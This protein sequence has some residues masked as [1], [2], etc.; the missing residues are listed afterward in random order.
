M[1]DYQ[2]I[3]RSVHSRTGLRPAGHHGQARGERFAPVVIDEL[4][5]VLPRMPL[6]FV[7]A[8]EG[9]SG[10]RLVGVQGLDDERNLYLH[11]R[12]EQ[13]VGGYIPACYR[14]HPFALVPDAHGELVL[15]VDQESGLLVEDPVEDAIDFFD[16]EG[17]LSEQ[18]QRTRQFL[19]VLADRGRRTQAAVD[20]LA[21]AGLIVP[22]PLRVRN[23]DSEIPVEGLYRIDEGGLARLD[24]RALGLLHAGEALAVAYGQIYSTPQV[25]RLGQL[26]KAHGAA[27]RKDLDLGA[28]FGWEDDLTFDFGN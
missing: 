20:A 6:A 9:A 10:F 26:R 15:G 1:T 25:E 4:S 21:A 5:R 7:E 17:N 8:Q 13:Y 2:P 27:P 3:E 12:T 19:E 28:L 14:A 24:G 16:A 22:W 11:P 18:L 23:D